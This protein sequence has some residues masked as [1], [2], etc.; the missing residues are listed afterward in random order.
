[1]NAYNKPLDTAAIIFCKL[2]IRIPVLMQKF[3][4]KIC[5]SMK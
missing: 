4:E 1:M 5:I 3:I 2:V